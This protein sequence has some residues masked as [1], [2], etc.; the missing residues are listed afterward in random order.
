MTWTTST[1]CSKVVRREVV[2]PDYLMRTHRFTNQSTCTHSHVTVGHHYIMHADTETN[3]RPQEACSA[4]S[5]FIVTKKFVQRAAW[6]HTRMSTHSTDD[7]W[8][9]LH[10]T[11]HQQYFRT[12]TTSVSWTWYIYMLCNSSFSSH[13]QVLPFLKPGILQES[14]GYKSPWWRPFGDRPLDLPFPKWMP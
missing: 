9:G 14:E 8:I 6:A 4:C 10:I 13:P 3:S 2:T 5:K 11:G 1:D 12:S 7:G